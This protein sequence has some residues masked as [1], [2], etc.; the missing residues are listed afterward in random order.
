MD[1][2]ALL[3]HTALPPVRE[4]LANEI[5]YSK[6]TF[7]PRWCALRVPFASLVLNTN[8]QA[9]NIKSSSV[10][11]LTDLKTKSI[12][13]AVIIHCFASH[14]TVRLCLSPNIIPHLHAMICITAEHSP[15]LFGAVLSQCSRASGLLCTQTSQVRTTARSGSLYVA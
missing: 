13:I 12:L 3:A 1:G 9:T 7:C 11:K 2:C 8:F 5:Q 6:G 15:I 4:S 10:C 14:I